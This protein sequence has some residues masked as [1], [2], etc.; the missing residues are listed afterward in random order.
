[1]PESA[2]TRTEATTPT[3]ANNSPTLA[4]DAALA[5]GTA[6]APLAAACPPCQ[7][8]AKDN[9]SASVGK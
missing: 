4:Q 9:V 2:R 8:R 6:R 5:R 3:N 7:R 1:M